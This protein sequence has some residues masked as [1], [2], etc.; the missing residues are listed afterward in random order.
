MKIKICDR[1]GKSINIG[2]EQHRLCLTRSVTLAYNFDLCKK[3][4]DDV[5]KFVVKAP[6]EEVKELLKI[7]AA[8]DNDD[9]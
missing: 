9:E 7:I 3:C 2:D 6:K 1:C 4:Y 5:I 8:K